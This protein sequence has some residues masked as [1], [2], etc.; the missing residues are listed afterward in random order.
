MKCWEFFLFCAESKWSKLCYIVHVLIMR[1]MHSCW[2]LFCKC[3]QAR[4]CHMDIVKRR[5]LHHHIHVIC[6]ANMML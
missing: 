4:L 2:M 6:N 5:H 3:M 1:L